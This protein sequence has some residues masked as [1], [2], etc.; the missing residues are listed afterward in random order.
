[1]SRSPQAFTSMRFAISISI[2]FFVTLTLFYFMQ[3]MI[4]GSGK[5][6]EKPENYR[7]VNFVRLQREPENEKP[8]APKPTPPRKSPLPP[9]SAT[10]TDINLAALQ[11][12][13]AAPQ[14]GFEIEP[15]A[16][17]QLGK[18]YLGPLIARTTKSLAPRKPATNNNI[19]APRKPALILQNET[20]PARVVRT[21]FVDKEHPNAVQATLGKQ[22]IMDSITAPKG[23]FPGL[24]G[25]AG[26][27][28]GEAVPVFKMEPKYPRKAA[29]SRIE[30]WVKVEFTITAK[31]AV[32]DAVVIDSRPRRTFDRSAVQSVR[33]WRFKPRV[34]DG[35][36]VQR[37]A[38]QVIEFKLARG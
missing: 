34:V 38:S 18:P 29:K 13:A 6:I 4:R 22:P 14:S 20:K 16:S 10:A 15:L 21:P 9:D 1:M 26:D 28:A 25:E 2:A 11:P 27:Y 31:G 37:K 23:A 24:H 19:K 3:Y 5:Q 36:P 35:R 12:P 33:K 32:T 17:M 30:G 7:V 8:Q